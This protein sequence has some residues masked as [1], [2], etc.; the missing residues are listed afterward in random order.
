MKRMLLWCCLVVA[1]CSSVFDVC[2][3]KKHCKPKN[4]YSLKKKRYKGPTL[5]PARC[6]TICLSNFKKVLKPHV[7]CGIKPGIYFCYYA[8]SVTCKCKK[9]CKFRKCLN[10]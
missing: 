9:Y 3:A 10:P 5:R 4:K 6:K 8:H 1:L 2:E 7:S